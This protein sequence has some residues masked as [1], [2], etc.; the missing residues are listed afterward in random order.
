V[1]S[2]PKRLRYFSQNDPNTLNTALRIFLR[3][4]NAN[5]YQHC[6][7]ANDRYREA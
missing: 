3:V 1:L 6:H 7:F 4:I 2:V 5:L